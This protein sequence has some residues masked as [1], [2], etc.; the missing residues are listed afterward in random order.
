MELFNLK[1][2]EDLNNQAV[3]PLGPVGPGGA[4]NVYV[5]PNSLHSSIFKYILSFIFY[6]SI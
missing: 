5:Q 4:Q 2:I 3:A 1:Y 6:A